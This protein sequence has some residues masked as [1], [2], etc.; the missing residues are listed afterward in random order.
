[1]TRDLTRA[2][3]PMGLAFLMCAADAACSGEATAAGA[4]PEEPA[5]ADLVLHHGHVLTM[6]D[7]EPVP[8]PTAVAVSAG[9]ILYV[10]DDQGALALAA[11]GARIIDVQGGTVIPGFIDSHCHLYGLGKSLAQLELRGTTSPQQIV[12]MVSS[13]AADAPGDGWLE[14]RGWD[15]NDWAVQEYPDRALLDAAT[16]AR[17]ALLRRVDG[18]A[19]WANTAALRLAGITA[20]TPDPAGG[21]IV[22]DAQGEP[23]GILIDNAVGLVTAVIPEPDDRE[24]RRRLEL[25]AAHCLE[26]GVT[27][28]HDAGIPWARAQVMRAMAADDKLGVRVYGMYDDD[29]AT[30][31]AA[32]A[33]GPTAAADGRLV[34]RAVKLYADGALGSRG[35]LLLRDYSDQP[36]NRGLAVTG[37]DRMRDVMRTMGAGGFQICTHAIGDAGNREV[38]DLYEQVLGELKL[39]DAR[40]RVEHAQILDPA[41]IPRFAMLGVIAAMQPVHCTSDMDWAGERL[42]EDRLAGAYA[43]RSLLETGARLCYGTDFPV[44]KVEPLEGLYAARTRQHPDGTPIGGWRPEEA[45]DGRTALWLYTAGGAWAAFQETELGLVAPGMRADLVVL[46]G[47]PVACAPGDLLTLR[48]NHTVAAGRVAWSAP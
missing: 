16:G 4:A 46:D 22:R 41:D 40:W 25:A 1:M 3:A 29:P 33:A 12:R 39:R 11:P 31:A 20:A 7:P 34:L 8:A 37:A 9:R 35:A 19:A 28:V 32:L 36:G 23:T 48:V 44:E 42:G 27:G 17:P 18:H 30:L 38:L 45:V 10:G 43:W 15:Q 21:A 5:R 47:D 14:G 24:V 2:L 6:S 13:F 26:R